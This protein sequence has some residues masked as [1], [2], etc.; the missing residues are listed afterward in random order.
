MGRLIGAQEFSVEAYKGTELTWLCNNP[1]PGNVMFW[2]HAVIEVVIKNEQGE[3]VERT[4]KRKELL[5]DKCV[6]MTN[7]KAAYFCPCC[8]ATAH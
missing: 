3:V 6:K 7:E 4:R 2:R 1:E 8:P 5:K